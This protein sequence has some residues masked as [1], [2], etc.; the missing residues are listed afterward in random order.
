M[1]QMMIVVQSEET[2]DELITGF[3]D[4]GVTMS[5]VVDATDALEIISH[6]V[7]LFAGFRLMAGG[8]ITRSRA[9]FSIVETDALLRRLKKFVG[10][11]ISGRREERGFYTVTPMTEGGPLSN[12]V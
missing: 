3:M 4:L 7:P 10:R 9:I 11:T 12:L 8:G 2:A 6:H 1:Y 5:A